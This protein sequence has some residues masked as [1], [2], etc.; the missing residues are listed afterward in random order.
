MLQTSTNT[1]VLQLFSEVVDRDDKRATN[2]TAGYRIRSSCNVRVLS[3]I[4]T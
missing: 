2:L 1:M 3:Y 4:L